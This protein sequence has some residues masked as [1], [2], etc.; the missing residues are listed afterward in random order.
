MSNP[1]E[2]SEV[3]WKKATKCNK[4][5]YLVKSFETVEFLAPVCQ[6]GQGYV[7]VV[8]VPRN[9]IETCWHGRKKLL[10]NNLGYNRIYYKWPHLCT[11]F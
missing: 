3:T 6:A 5:R 4:R 10:L 11:A 8:D 7:V 2:N 9:S 1:V